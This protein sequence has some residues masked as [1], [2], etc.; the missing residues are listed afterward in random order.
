MAF[1]C[2]RSILKYKMGLI[3]KTNFISWWWFKT[4]HPMYTTWSQIKKSVQH[5]TPL[6]QFIILMKSKSYQKWP[7]W[8]VEK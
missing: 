6:K 3:G 1:F 5:W 7:S 2:D 4:S 8:D